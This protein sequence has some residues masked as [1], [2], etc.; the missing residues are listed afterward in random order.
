VDANE[1]LIV[2]S[3][4]AQARFWDVP[5]E[6][7]TPP[8]RV[9]VAIW[10]LDADVNNGGFD[11]YYLNSSGDHARS[12][13]GALRTI[14]AD[15]TARIVER[16]NAAFGPDGPPADR[17]ARLEAL[18]ALDD[19]VQEQ[20]DELDVEFYAYPDDL[21]QLLYAYVQANRTDIRGAG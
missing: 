18:P 1:W 5:V 17:A 21:T 11:Q 2:L 15:R 10:S 20:W 13:P 9:F 12:A 3:E 19:E 16:A 4:S 8:E 7:L 6:E 14:G